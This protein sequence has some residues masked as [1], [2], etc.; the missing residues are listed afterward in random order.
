MN[1]LANEKSPYLL[2]HAH[3]PVDWF[4]WGTEAFEKA[5]REDKPIFLSIGYS[6]CHWCHVMERESFESDAIAGLLNRDYVPIKVDRE[7]RPDVDRIYMTFVQATTGGGGWPMSVWLT[8]ELQPFFGGT[9]FPPQNRWG[10]PGFGSVLEQISSAW[11]S[12]REQIVD[13]ARDVVAQ[14]QKQ[15]SVEPGRGGPVDKNVLDS[16]FFVFR[17]SFDSHLGGFGGAPKFPRPSVYNFLL[18]YHS[19]TKNQ[20]ALEMVLLTL[21][22]MAKG[23][24]HDQLGG[25]FHRYSV[26]ERWFVPHFEKMLYDQ[27]QLAISCLEAFQITRDPQYADTARGIFD[28][29]LRDMTD[30]EGG[31][32]SA[33]DADS[34][35]DPEEPHVKGEGAFYIWSADEIRRLVEAPAADWFC[36]RYGVAEGGNVA[37]DPHSE[38]TGR[39]ILYRAATSEETAQQFGRPHEEVREGLRRAEKILLEARSKRVRPHLDDKVLTSWN[40]LMI[41]AFALGGAVLDEPRYAQAARRAAEFLIAR[42]HDSQT[43]VLLRRYRQGE[44]AIPGFLDDYAMFAQGLLDLYEAQFDLR[45][46]ELAVRLTEKQRDLFEDRARGG[47]F[48]SA[49]GDASLVMRVKDDYDGAEPS[50]NSVALM[51][52][53]RLAEFTDRAGF[54]ESAERTLAAFAPRLTAAPVGLPQMLAA[55]EFRL[56][57]PRQI[58]I[59]GDKDAADTLALT[60]TLYSHFVPPRIVLLV[61]S[62]ETR[63]ALAARIPAIAAMQKTAGRAA[64]YVCRN[65]TCQLPVSEPAQFVELIQ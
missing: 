29:V 64:V 13:S 24:M 45:H 51:N 49:E 62:T 9:Y 37:S 60:R 21:R 7:E 40:G 16:G 26:D 35:I 50:G 46:L 27:A 30:A 56:G 20:E 10:Q 63:Q 12:G 4:P 1:R 41:S 18:R 25:G 19:R 65:Y 2:Q 17:R 53:L 57:E 15:T 42:M 52:L 14:L 43:G 59:A 32:Y 31:F 5:R 48:S 3:N 28:Y 33:E 54:R 34:A 44:A 47:F 23:G 11:R 38:F 22:E 58:V 55:C 6:N 8:P 36:Y 39:N 61:D